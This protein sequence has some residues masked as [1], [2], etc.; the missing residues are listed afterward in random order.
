MPAALLAGATCLLLA[1]LL[2]GCG[3]QTADA[4]QDRQPRPPQTKPS[5]RQAAAET[6]AEAAETARGRSR[7]RDD[8][9]TVTISCDGEN[10]V[11]VAKDLTGQALAD[12]LMDQWKRDHPEADWVAEEK[13]KHAFKPPADNSDLLQGEPGQGRTPTATTPSATS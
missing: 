8:V 2:V 5:R 12:A 3:Q 9:E 6:T 10:T 11:T 1:A 13:E 7:R 4:V